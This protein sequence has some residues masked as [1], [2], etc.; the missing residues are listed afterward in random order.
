[1]SE[2]T[3]NTNGQNQEARPQRRT[4]TDQDV[5]IAKLNADKALAT[6]DGVFASVGALAHYFKIAEIFAQSSLVPQHYK[7]KPGDC[8][9]AFELAREL[10][11][12][13]LMCMQSTYMVKGT[14]GFKTTFLIALA[15]ARGVFRTPIRWR[16]KKL[17]PPTLDAWYQRKEGR[18]EYEMENFSVV[19]YVEDHSGTVLES[20]EVTSQMAIDDGWASGASGNEKYRTLPQLML[21]YR[22][23]TML[24][25]LYA[26]EVLMG[27][28]SLEE[29]E[30][31]QAPTIDV[32][33]D[34]P[35]T[36]DSILKAS[37]DAAAQAD[38]AAAEDDDQEDVIDAEE[39]EPEKEAEPA[40]EEE[41]PAAQEAE[42]A[43]LTGSSF[44]ASQITEMKALAERN[45]VFWSDVEARYAGGPLEELV[46]DGKT[47]TAM[48]G[49]VVDLIKKLAKEQKG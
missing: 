7:G 29:I 25:R 47:P 9:V 23:A 21:Q 3:N 38:A 11:V 1:M 48:E 27:F 31:F 43:S 16:V 20:P 41:K 24:I 42:Q 39:V 14:P 15:N 35:T 30:S 5:E 8:L 6:F 46:I 19:A 12:H 49:E 10:R 4:P 32:T 26:P 44:S 28:H 34:G 45:G 2:H 22:A 17:D 18:I 36:L 13:P 40:P 33:P 37:E